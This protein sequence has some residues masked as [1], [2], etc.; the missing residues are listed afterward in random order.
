MMKSSRIN[1][2]YSYKHICYGCYQINLQ[3]QCGKER[4]DG[5]NFHI[6]FSRKYIP[7]Y[8]NKKKKKHIHVHKPPYKYLSVYKSM[9]CI[10]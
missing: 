1:I 8:Y 7:P 10:K 5:A 9:V 4:M 2:Y 6:L 3:S